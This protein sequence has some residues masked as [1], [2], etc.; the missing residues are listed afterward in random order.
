MT[1]EEVSRILEAEAVFVADLERVDVEMACGADLM[2]DVL[3]FAKKGSL[4]LTGLTNTQ[5]V[6]TSEMA[7]IAAVCFVR[8]KTPPEET[9]KLAAANGLPL[10]VTELPMFEACGR[11]YKSGLKGCSE[12]SP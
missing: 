4:L 11:L 3:A 10:L 2:S 5:V 6:R 9:S 7:D 12:C 1:L 8:G